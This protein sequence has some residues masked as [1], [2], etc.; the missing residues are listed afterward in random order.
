MKKFAFKNLKIFWKF[1]LSQIAAIIFLALFLG[2]ATTYIVEDALSDDHYLYADT[3][4]NA[5]CGEINYNITEYD[6]FFLL[7]IVNSEIFTRYF[8]NA[9]ELNSTIERKFLVQFYQMQTLREPIISAYAYT[10]REN[11]YYATAANCELVE[12]ESHF[13]SDYIKQNYYDIYSNTNSGRFVV[14]EDQPGS[15]FYIRAIYSEFLFT[16]QGVF[17]AELDSNTFFNSFLQE[18]LPEK[19][20]ISIIYNDKVQVYS[21]AN[22]I[23]LQEHLAVNETSEFLPLNINGEEY[24]LHSNLTQDENWHVAYHV[25][26]K[27]LYY[28]VDDIL[29]TITVAIL[30]YLILA[31]VVTFLV[32]SNLTSNIRQLAKQIQGIREGKLLKPKSKPGKDEI[33]ELSKAFSDMSSQMDTVMTKLVNEQA[34]QEKLQNELLN[35]QYSKLLAQINPHFLYNVLESVNG[36][37]KNKGELEIAAVMQ[38][39]GALMRSSIQENK[40]IIYLEDEISYIEDYFSIYEFMLQDR[41]SIIYDIGADVEKAKIPHLILQPIAENAIKH[42]AEHMSEKCFIAITAFSEGNDLNIIISDNGLGIEESVL[43]NLFS[44]KAQKYKA[45]AHIG[46]NS[47]N[48]RLKILYGEEYGLSV[49]SV[50]NEGTVVTVKLPL[51]FD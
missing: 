16:Y 25:S 4:T 44:E 21:T 18:Q 19:G 7:N 48:K 39:L 37:A 33:G 35:A 28:K 43:D 34:K 20:N 23:I 40:D 42:S 38:K 36:Y 46:I 1:F 31:L 45:R 51:Q 3:T 27:D 12:D 41:V 5:I 24:L 49:N 13:I 29:I 8:N 15:I 22:N 47:V 2:I 14:F 9:E 32:S 26:N 10:Y 30:A 17:V 11:L 50:I 6:N